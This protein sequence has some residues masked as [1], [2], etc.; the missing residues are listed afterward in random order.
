VDVNGGRAVVVDAGPFME[1]FDAVAVVAG[2]CDRAGAGPVPPFGV[3]LRGDVGQ[4]VGQGVVAVLRGESPPYRWR[5][6]G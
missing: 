4:H 2:A 3:D 6:G 5:Y 1:L